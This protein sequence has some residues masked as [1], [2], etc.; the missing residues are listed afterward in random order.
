[1]HG[2]KRGWTESLVKVDEDEILARSLQNDGHFDEPGD[3]HPSDSGEDTV[4]L[5]TDQNIPSTSLKHA[6]GLPFSPGFRRVPPNP[7]PTGPWPH[8]TSPSISDRLDATPST[9]PPQPPLLLVHYSVRLGFL[10]IPFMIYDFFNE[11][12]NM[13]NGPDTDL[14]FDLETEANYGRSYRDTP[15]IIENARKG[16][17]SELPAKLKV[18][19]TLARNERE[20]TK[21]EMN[22]PPPTEV[23][24][25]AQRLK[26]E[27]RWREDENA[28]MWLKEGTDVKWDPRFEGALDI[29]RDPTEEEVRNVSPIPKDEEWATEK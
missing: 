19:R 22:Y 8:S 12:K 2:L 4:G 10:N 7:R 26:K 21:D 24:L 27:K 17:Y 20:P 9:I 18:A 1:M 13:R 23:E 3:G 11:R 6:P 16:Y 5:E 28:F 15:K 14:T 29:F 25:R